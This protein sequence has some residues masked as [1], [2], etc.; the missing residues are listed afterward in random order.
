MKNPFKRRRKILTALEID[1]DWLKI[2]QVETFVKERKV[3]RI[4][5]EKITSL[6]DE[7]I[8]QRIKGLSKDM[9]INSDFLIIS[10]SH[11]QAVIRNVELP[12][13][14]LAEIKSMVELQIGKQ[15]P[16]AKEEIIY[17]YEILST[18]ADGYSS[19]MLIIVHRDII[20]RLSK[21]LKEAGLKADK[22]SLSSEGLLKWSHYSFKQRE[23]E[24][25][26]VLIDISY[27]ASDIELIQRDKLIFSR[28]ISLGFSQSLDSMDEWL[29]KF[30][31]QINRFIYAYQNEISNKEISKIIITGAEKLTAD[32]DGTVIK[33]KLGLD[34]EVIPQF[35]NIHLIEESQGS[36]NAL[37]KEVSFSA[38]LGSV[39]TYPEQRINLIPQE[40]LIERR[41]KERGKDLYFLGISLVLILV[42]VSSIFL[43]RMYN[44]EQ[45]L[46]QLKRENLKIEEKVT[47]LD[48]MMEETEFIK[49]RVFT[50]DFCLKL[51]YETHAVISPDLYLSSISFDGEGQLIARGTSNNMSTVFNFL[52]AMEES[53]YFQNV[54][55]KYARTRR[56]SGE[57]VT[58]FE[59]VCPLTQG[60]QEVLKEE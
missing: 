3:S 50:K 31:E 12:S 17:D 43:G 33:N 51:I 19:I 48:N 40:L 56:V 45:Y 15:T 42:T 8:S 23:D 2:V 49:K 37:T 54:N 27:N 46:N 9:K 14:S 39:L 35:Q 6:S 52:D 36:Y 22:I 41:L 20:E 57:D 53:K 55:T 26:Y 29:S 34:I 28:N 5:L 10:V 21:I 59:I 11:T 13:T 18:A 38:L 60:L 1:S 30:I 25:P 58:D 16:F 4:I 44:K 7:E 47:R 32:I 24:K